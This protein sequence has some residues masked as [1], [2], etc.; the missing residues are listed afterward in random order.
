MDL[1]GQFTF[2]AMRDTA[3][4]F[5]RPLII[6][7]CF[8]IGPSTVLSRIRAVV[9]NAIKGEVFRT[10]AHVRKE[11][12][13]VMTPFVADEN[14]SASVIAVGGVTRVVAAT[15]HQTPSVVFARPRSAMN[16]RLYKSGLG[17]EASA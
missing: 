16:A 14:P 1:R 6:R 10:L 9:V 15:V 5:A 7:L 4:L 12:T 13:E 8:P 11:L 2:R 17:I 3:S